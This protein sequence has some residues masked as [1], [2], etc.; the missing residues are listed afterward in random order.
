M[1]LGK[2]YHS[3]DAKNRLVIPSK[4]ADELDGKLTIAPS[5]TEPCILLY[6]EE[7]WRNYY[8]KVT[9]LPASMV[10]EIA[11]YLFSGAQ[12]VVPDAQN[13][14]AIP[15]NMIGDAKIKHNIVTVGIGEYCEI[16]GEEIY[17]EMGIG[18]P[19]ENIREA[20]RSLGL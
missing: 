16:W 10:H 1:L 14:I 6:G 9:S 5:V 3:L 4:L 13:R 11:H 20:L 19:P 2:Y 18:K 8:N 15:Q 17:N 7:A 12:Q